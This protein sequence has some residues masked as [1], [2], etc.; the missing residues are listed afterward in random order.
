[1]NKAQQGSSLAKA[2]AKEELTDAQRAAYKLESIFNFRWIA[3]HLGKHSHYV[4]SAA[5][6]VS[7][8]LRLELSRIG[9]FAEI[10]YA[11]A[12][13]E[14][15]WKN[16]DLLS[17]P[18]Y[19]L[20]HYDVLS[21]ARVLCTLRGRFTDVRA[22]LAYCE[23]RRQLIV[24]FSGT[25]NYLQALIDT[26]AIAISYPGYAKFKE[27]S[28]WKKPR[29]HAGFWRLYRGLR[30]KVITELASQLAVLDVDEIV[31]TGHSLGG[32]MSQYF[33]MDILDNE[34]CSKYLDGKGFDIPAHIAIKLVIFGSPRVGNETFADL[35][36]SY[37][38]SLK[39]DRGEDKYVE[40]CVKGYN[41]GMSTTSGSFSSLLTETITGAPALPP[42][43]F[44]YRHPMQ[45]TYFGFRGRLYC[46][47]AS[48]NECINF[49]VDDGASPEHSDGDASTFFPHGGH[50]YYN[51]RDMEKVWRRMGWIVTKKGK[52]L[53]DDWESIYPQKLKNEQSLI[54]RHRS[55]FR[56]FRMG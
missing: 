19:P 8:E 33:V 1:M 24:A 13:P 14:I 4:L 23:N 22:M 29:V 50:N 41:D 16:L 42:H 53:R 30:R 6:R 18:N 9:Q 55:H 56:L 47:P 34:T 39:A 25:R 43:S 11:M 40:Y 38:K 52:G 35:Y 36:R 37:V 12:D 3:Q 54:E 21:E 28:R 45:S 10:A 49:S 17:R 26:N 5:D 27:K 2:V 20:E 46:I 51:D 48:E 44:G 32:A 7:P 31:M 15:I